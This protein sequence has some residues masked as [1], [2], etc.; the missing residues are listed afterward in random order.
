MIQKPS[1][2]SGTLLVSIVRS[3]RWSIGTRRVAAGV[4]C[5]APYQIQ[6]LGNVLVCAAAP[7]RGTSLGDHFGGFARVPVCV[8]RD[9][10]QSRTDGETE[11][12]R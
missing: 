10:T 5:P 4:G 9:F 6:Q 8:S 1:V 11:S 7:G 3:I 2:T 12:T